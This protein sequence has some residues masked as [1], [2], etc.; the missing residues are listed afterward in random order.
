MKEK[1]IRFCSSIDIECTGIAPAER[2]TEFAGVWKKQLDRGYVSGFEERDFK[3]R[4]D[5]R[6][7][8]P[9]AKSVIVCLFPYY[10]DRADGANLSVSTYSRDYHLIAGER[11]ELI[12]NFLKKEIPGFVYRAFVDNG[13]LSDRYLAYRA[14]LGFFGINGHLITEKYGSYV[15]IGYLINNYP[16]EPDKPQERTCR[17]C[18]KC[19]SACPG[20]CILG[21]FTI[22]PLKCK[23][24][25]TQKKGALS[26]EEMAIIRRNSLIWGCD[27]CQEVC[28]HNRQAAKTAIA[29]FAEKL[30]PVLDYRE[31][32]EL[33][34]RE[35]RQRYGDR[36]FSWRGKN[37]LLRNYEIINNA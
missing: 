24:Y 18:L 10:T 14:G 29:G 25:L 37:V 1:L 9:E 3:R 11:L 15:F 16:F 26:E 32:K 36:A 27:V 13:P 21:D 17:Q 2:Y 12:G 4:I 23:S 35:F 28:P 22:N 31:L 30:L 20:Q 33:S 5:P 8:L 6:E 7:T 19:V 34:N